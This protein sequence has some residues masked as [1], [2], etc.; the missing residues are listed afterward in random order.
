VSLYG[1]QQL[2]TTSNEYTEE[3]KNL[4]KKKDAQQKCCVAVEGGVGLLSAETEPPLLLLH[5]LSSKAVNLGRVS[6]FFFPSDA[7]R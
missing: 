3:K 6:F 7:E 5:V 2:K 4:E 1:I